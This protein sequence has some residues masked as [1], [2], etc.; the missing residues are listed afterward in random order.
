VSTWRGFILL[1]LLGVGTLHADERLWLSTN[2]YDLVAGQVVS[3]QFFL[4]ADQA[5]AAGLFAD[6][7]FVLARGQATFE[8]EHQGDTWVLAGQTSLGGHQRDHVRLAGQ[9]LLVRGALDRSLFAL[10]SA[11][12]LS[13]GSVVRGQVV[14]AG[15]NVTLEGTVGGPVLLMGQSVTLAGLVDG[16]VRI[17]AQ[18]IVIMPGA[19]VQGDLIYT[20]PK[21]VFLD[22]HD[23]VG[24]QLK[25][26][27]P[28]GPAPGGTTF[29]VESI[30]LQLFQMAAALL[31][32][33]LLAGLFPRSIGRAARLIRFNPLRCLMA[34]L[35]SL[36]VVPI[37]AIAGL[38]TV[39]GIPLALLVAGFAGALLYLG[40][41]VVALVV[42]SL[43]L[44]RRGSQSLGV[45][46]G[47]MAIGMIVLYSAFALPVMGGSLALLVA[48][49][50]AGSL[51]WTWLRS[52]V[53]PEPTPPPV[54]GPQAG[55]TV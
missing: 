31:T 21:E 14:A 5:R 6:D 39:I 11:V 9:S 45:V 16:D 33:L 13:T 15:E 34:G 26:M 37:V 40:K 54:P 38:L 42:G 29:S 10:G 3:N 30:V 17:L 35:S 36:F 25:R 12:V 32:G 22:H 53:R 27:Q 49:M 18:D 19:R 51:W 24:G 44:R 8:G 47:A 52:E 46:M 50:G 4:V 41:V 1:G 48:L 43:L 55:P 20:S 2:Q 28:A 7:I 23:Q